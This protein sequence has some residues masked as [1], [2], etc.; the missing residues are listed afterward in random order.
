[1]PMPAHVT[2]GQGQ[3]LI[4]AGFN[5]ALDGYADP[6]VVLGKKRFLTKLFSETGIPFGVEP[7]AAKPA[8][9]IRT[10]GPSDSVEKLGEDESYRLTVSPTGIEL[11]APNALGV[12]HGLQTFLQLVHITPQGFALP[13]SP[14]TTSRGSPG[15]A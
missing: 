2:L 3:F 5:I 11:T 10:A 1:M 14:S 15:A 13:L 12:L 6:R 8:F 4:D 7:S 9:V